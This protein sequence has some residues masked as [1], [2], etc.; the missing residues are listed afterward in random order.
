MCRVLPG[1][2]GPE[3]LPGPGTWRGESDEPRCAALPPFPPGLSLA[4]HHSLA[5]PSPSRGGMTRSDQNVSATQLV[6]LSIAGLGRCRQSLLAHLL[7]LAS[8]GPKL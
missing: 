8:Q 4:Q 6:F 7:L 3:G 5:L 1:L 2:P